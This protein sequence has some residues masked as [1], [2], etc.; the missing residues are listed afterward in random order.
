MRSDIR[1]EKRITEHAVV[2]VGFA[3][4]VVYVN[5]PDFAEAPQSV[6]SGWFDDSWHYHDRWYAVIR[7]RW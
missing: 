3:E 6:A 4:D 5:D 7:R 1:E 2:V